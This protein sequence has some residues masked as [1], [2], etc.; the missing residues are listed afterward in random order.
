[1]A[2][3]EAMQIR[4]RPLVQDTP[5]WTANEKGAFSV[6]SAW[7][8]FRKV[9]F[10]MCFTVWRALRDRL[11]TDARNIWRIIC[12][13]KGIPFTG[14]SFRML[15]VNWWKAKTKN[16]VEA[17]L[18][19]C[20]PIVTTWE[21]WKAI[22]GVKYGS[23]R[24]NIVNTQFPKFNTKPIRSSVCH[25][26]NIN[27][28]F[29]KTIITKWNKPPAFFVKLNSDGSCKNGLCGGG[30]VMDNLGCLIAAF[31]INLGPGTSNW[32]EAQSLLFGI[33]WC[34]NNGL[35]CILVKTD[36]KLLVDCLNG[37]N[38]VPWRISDEINELR[39]L[40]EQT[41]FNLNHC[42]RESNQVADKLASLSHES[43]QNQ[44]FHNFDE[45]PR[46]V[47]G[48]MNMDKWSLLAFRVVDKRTYITFEPP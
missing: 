34:I 4:L 39:S 22:C 10:K 25:L 12:G 29:K 6:A 44:L 46:Q 17:C 30:G 38:C 27:I 21:I 9:P 8:I 45:V 18:I 1:M 37:N 31:T 48:I 13:V 33:K 15:L 32:T 7:N 40:R 3:I 26:F 19:N 24:L 41:I 47:R 5:V 20:L 35:H 43:L 23:E 28:G 2:T 42:F 36:S 11:P 14:V 16:P